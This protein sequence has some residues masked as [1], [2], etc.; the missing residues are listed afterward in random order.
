MEIIKFEDLPSLK[1]KGWQRVRHDGNVTVNERGR[2]P[3][4]EGVQHSNAKSFLK[5]LVKAAREND[6]GMDVEVTPT[7][8]RFRVR[9]K[10]TRRI[11]P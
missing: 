7:E 11:L 8:I 3:L 2:V 4:P 5:G 1:G 6:L 10:A 9:E